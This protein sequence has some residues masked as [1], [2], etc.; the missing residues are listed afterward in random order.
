[1]Q[2]T[3]ITLSAAF[4][5]AGPQPG[6]AERASPERASPEQVSA[7]TYRVRQGLVKLIEDRQVPARVPGVLD[8]VGSPLVDAEGNPVLDDAG[9]QKYMDVREGSSVVRGQVVAEIDDEME[10]RQKMAAEAKLDVS[11]LQAN[12]TVRVDYAKAAAEV[13]AMEVV[14]AQK[15]NQTYSATVPSMEL[16]R[17]KLAERQAVLSIKQSQNDLD[18]DKESVRVREAEDEIAALEI[19]RRRI[20]AP[21]D[22]IIVKRYVDEKEWVQPGDPVMRI[23]QIDRLR[24]EGFVDAKQISPA[25]VKAGQ[26]VTLRLDSQRSVPLSSSAVG[27]PI[28]GQVVFVSPEIVNGPKFEV[29]AEVDNVWLTSDPSRPED[30][31]WLLLPGMEL[32]MTIHLDDVRRGGNVG[33]AISSR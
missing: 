23:V 7:E 21:I 14:Q 17:L 10:Q 29:W 15:A 12:N 25:R 3:L 22:G 9:N 30:G 1:M 20:V 11:K 33:P 8:K 18:I 6:S 19:D 27:R 28:E 5:L 16:T 31:H 26:K 4:L 13:A 24:I 2:A 32:D